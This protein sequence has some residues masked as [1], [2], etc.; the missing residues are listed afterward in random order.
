MAKIKEKTWADYDIG[1]PSKASYEELKTAVRRAAKAANQR[2]LRLERA[3]ATK[4]V[5]QSAMEDLGNMRMENGK[6]AGG[7]RR[8]KENPGKLTI[9]QM[10]HE[11]RALRSFLSAKTSTVQ[12]RKEA[13]DKRYQTAVARG[14]Q[15]TPEEFETDIES[16]FAERNESLFSSDQIYE[17][18][19]SGDLD[20]L[21]DIVEGQKKPTRGRSIIEY[22]KRSKARPK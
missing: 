17:S 9:N 15:G 21:D 2:L 13:G 10:R 8:F 7:R 14:Y 3:G 6:P 22:M 1:D 20:L 19:I 11:Y 18:V 4:G 12:G 5:Y 16:A